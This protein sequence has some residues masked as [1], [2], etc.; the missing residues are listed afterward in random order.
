[1]RWHSQKPGLVNVLHLLLLFMLIMTPIL[2][3]ELLYTAFE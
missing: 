1:M 3:S 2:I